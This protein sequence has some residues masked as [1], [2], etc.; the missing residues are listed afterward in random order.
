MKKTILLLA[1]LTAASC[2][3]EKPPTIATTVFCTP[4]DDCN[5]KFARAVKWVND[6]SAYDI[7]AQTQTSIATKGPDPHSPFSQLTVTM[8]PMKSGLSRIDMGS[9]CADIFQCTPTG[10]DLQASFVKAVDPQH[11]MTWPDLPK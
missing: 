3:N 11:N 8:T 10:A 2:A 4:G 6:T 7:A 9:Q 1:F 5:A